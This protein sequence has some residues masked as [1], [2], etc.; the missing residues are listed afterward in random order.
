MAP[1]PGF[2][3]S[4]QDDDKFAQSEQLEILDHFQDHFPAH[5]R[6]LSLPLPTSSFPQ[7]WARGLQSRMAKRSSSPDR[8]TPSRPAQP[9]VSLPEATG[10]QVSKEARLE[11][12][13]LGSERL[14]PRHDD[15]RATD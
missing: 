6:A 9:N 13:A 1:C 14:S 12:V 3:H 8:P 2:F 10:R 15:D 7:G 4:L 5:L 11:G